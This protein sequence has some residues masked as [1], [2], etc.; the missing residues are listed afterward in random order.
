MKVNSQ[1]AFAMSEISQRQDTKNE[2]ENDKFSSLLEKSKD[3]SKTGT[4]ITRGVSDA[5]VQSF[6]NDLTSM[7]ASAFWMNFNLDKIQEKIDKK[8][9]ELADKLGLNK[10]S[11]VGDKELTSEQKK[12]ALAELEKLLD[13]YV[14]KLMKEMEAKKELENNQKSSPLANFFAQL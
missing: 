4:T 5:D 2:T 11:K 8:R 6:I 3:D 13:E 1:Q 7:G 10:D 14:K 12:E 9:E